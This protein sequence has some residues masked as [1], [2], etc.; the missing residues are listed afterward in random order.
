MFDTCPFCDSFDLR[1]TP[2]GK[3][4]DS[5]F[6]RSC[7]EAWIDNEEGNSTL[8]KSDVEPVIDDPNQDS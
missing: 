4:G 7:G 1:I 6:C 3:T 8:W 5:Y 2:G